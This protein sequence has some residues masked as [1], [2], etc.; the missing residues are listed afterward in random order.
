MASAMQKAALVP[1]GTA[2]ATT[3]SRLVPIAGVTDSEGIRHMLILC[4]R[5]KTMPARDLLDVLTDAEAHQAMMREQVRIRAIKYSPTST[6]EAIA[7]A[8]ADWEVCLAAYRER[9]PL[10]T[11]TFTYTQKDVDEAAAHGF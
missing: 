8:Q 2:R 9:F 10:I 5:R 4:L 1:A 11:G 3:L 6:E 7:Q